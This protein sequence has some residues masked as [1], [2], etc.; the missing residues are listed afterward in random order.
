[1]L[2]QVQAA[3][4]PDALPLAKHQIEVRTLPLRP[5]GRASVEPVNIPRRQS[6]RRAAVVEYA[7]RTLQRGQKPLVVRQGREIRCLQLHRGG[8]D[9]PEK[10][11]VRVLRSGGDDGNLGGGATA[12]AGGDV[13]RGSDMP[14]DNAH[15][16]T[17]FN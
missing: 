6:Q 12:P 7:D 17:L 5:G 10:V 11:P 8:A 15:Y 2:P 4:F 13:F 3:H 16:I 1:M 9:A 14:N